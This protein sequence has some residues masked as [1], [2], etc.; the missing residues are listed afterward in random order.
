LTD[1][2]SASSQLGT[3]HRAAIGITEESDA[4]AVVVSEETGQMSVAHSGRLIRNLDQDRL[5]RVLRTLMKLDTQL[6]TKK[7]PSAMHRPALLEIF[8]RNN[9]SPRKSS[10]DNPKARERERAQTRG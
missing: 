7:P 8:T 1:N 4:L 2:I 9:G 3:R 6:D 5:R 10:L